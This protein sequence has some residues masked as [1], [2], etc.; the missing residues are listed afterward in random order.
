MTNVQIKSIDFVRVLALQGID[1]DAGAPNISI[2]GG[3]GGQ[4]G[5]FFLEIEC[6]IGKINLTLGPI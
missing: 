2:S 4:G 5:T 3:R 6:M 1:A